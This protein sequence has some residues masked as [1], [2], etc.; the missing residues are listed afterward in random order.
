[1][2]KGET[3]RKAENARGKVGEFPT[4]HEG[5]EKR[6]RSCVVCRWGKKPK[7]NGWEEWR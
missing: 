1:M 5:A 7:P 6:R 3:R 4:A 2:V